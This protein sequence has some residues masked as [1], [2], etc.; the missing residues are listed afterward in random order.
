MSN[1]MLSCL[2][3]PIPF[4]TL[5][6]GDYTVKDV[7]ADGVSVKLEA[8]WGMSLWV[9]MPDKYKGTMKGKDKNQ[10]VWVAVGQDLSVEWKCVHSSK[11]T[12][13]NNI[14]KS[15]SVRDLA[16][17]VYLFERLGP[18]Y[19]TVDKLSPTLVHFPSS[20]AG[21]VPNTCALVVQDGEVSVQ[22][23]IN[24]FSNI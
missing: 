17:G 13:L 1:E 23:A 11:V 9:T 22:D 21:N 18:I 24:Y 6:A 5:I 4:S 16:N 8:S 20:T 19:G 15:V 10:V 14:N 7:R 12:D 2:I 3:N